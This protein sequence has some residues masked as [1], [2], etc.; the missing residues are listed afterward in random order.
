MAITFKVI[1][2]DHDVLLVDADGGL[3]SETAIEA[4]LDRTT[5]SYGTWPASTAITAEELNP[6]IIVIWNTG[7][8][9]PTLRPSDRT[10][11]TEYVNQG[12]K[13]LIAGQNIGWDMIDSG[14]GNSDPTFYQGVLHANFIDD[15]ASEMS[16]EGSPGNEI[17]EGLAFNLVD[18]YSPDV[19]EP[20][21][22]A[23]F[24]L[25]RY[26]E[27]EVAAI[28][29]EDVVYLA[30]DPA[31]IDDENQRDTLIFNIL[32]ALGLLFDDIEAEEESTVRVPKAVV[33][34]QNVPNPFNP[35][36]RIS[37]ELAQA[38]AVNLTIYD[39]SGKLVK[40]LIS[41]RQKEGIYAVHWDGTDDHCRP[42]S[43]GIYFSKLQTESNVQTLKMVLLK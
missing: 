2:D 19:I 22:D 7:R 38:T 10:I 6:F 42:V 43:S 23:T 30:F 40:T 41:D 11:L 5:L 28:N 37:Y 4:T 34:H 33:L 27:S 20:V 16:V 8:A 31:S 12:G 26:T 17:S 32:Q 15:V 29:T 9:L 36:T 24:D 18:Q 14:S 13:L 25:L 21:D 35:T 39:L 3:G 1:T